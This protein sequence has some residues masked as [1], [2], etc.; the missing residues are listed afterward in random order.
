MP[1]P[2]GLGALAARA[3]GPLLG[4]LPLTAPPLQL[5][6]GNLRRPLLILNL[7][8][9]LFQ[10]I[11]NLPSKDLLYFPREP[12]MLL[13]TVVDKPLQLINSL[14]SESSKD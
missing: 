3:A 4:L 11:I 5:Q 7:L 1:G 10:A 6:L 13:L 2:L 8:N 14:R 9:Q 12:L